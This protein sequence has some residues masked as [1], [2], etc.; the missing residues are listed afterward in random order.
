MKLQI[1]KIYI[2]E[3]VMRAIHGQS[4]PIYEGFVPDLKLAIN[5]ATSFV[6]EDSSRYEKHD[7]AT[8][9]TPTPQPEL[10]C[11]VE[12]SRT[13]IEDAKILAGEDDP[14]TRMCKLIATTLKGQ[15]LDASDYEE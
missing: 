14:E 5:Q 9:I 1:W 15:N 2:S 6:D 10:I 13:Q 12:M 3:G 8:Q 4:Y 7:A 11:E